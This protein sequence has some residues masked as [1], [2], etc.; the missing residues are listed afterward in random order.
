MSIAGEEE[1]EEPEVSDMSVL[2]VCA[3][4]LAARQHPLDEATYREA[5][6]SFLE[7]IV[8][9]TLGIGYMKRLV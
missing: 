2:R 7:S 4:D 1:R 3:K 8:S 5:F 9:V 6:D